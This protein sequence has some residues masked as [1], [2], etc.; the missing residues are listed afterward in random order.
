MH[1]LSKKTNLYFIIKAIKL[2]TNLLMYCFYCLK[3]FKFKMLLLTVKPFLQM[4]N[5]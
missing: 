1:N 5:L 4:L 2:A 3:M